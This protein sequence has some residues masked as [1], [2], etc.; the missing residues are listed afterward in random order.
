M[1]LREKIAAAVA[2]LVTAGSFSAVCPAFAAGFSLPEA[3]SAGIGLANALVAN[4]EETGAFPY[5][6][7]AMGFHATSSVAVGAIMIGP[8]FT[9]ET[10]TGSHDSQGADW[11]AGPMLQAALRVGDRWRVGLGVTAPFGLETRWGDGTFPDLSGT[12]P[13]PFPVPSPLDPNVPL[14]H[15]TS[16]KLEIVDVSPSVVYRVSEDLSLAGGLDVYWLKRAQLDSTAG[17]L[18]GDGIDLGFNLSALYRLGAWSFGAVFRSGATIGVQGDYRP[19]SRTLVAIGAIPPAQEAEV[20]LDL[21]WRLQLGVR[22]LITDG[23]AIELDWTRTGWSEFDTLA[24]K[25]ERTGEVIFTDINDW[26][27][28]SA[29]RIGATCQLRPE[30]QLRV[31]YSYDQTGQGDAHFNARV[32]DSDRHLFSVGL[33]QGFPNGFSLEAGYMYVKGKDRNY[34]GDT[35]YVGQRDINGTDA[36]QGRYEMDA[37]LLGIE[38]VKVF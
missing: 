17:E 31:G 23:L 1:S 10:A 27:D 35:P 12:A 32:P 9:V 6:P 33:A 36:I 13:L 15:P 28:S 4:P 30:T 29:Y 2:G 18:S 24:V 11:L 34:R 26:E 19:L 14:G 7:A 3:S 20:S 5:N 16:S 22:R 37:H 21:P 38:L 8:S 25:G